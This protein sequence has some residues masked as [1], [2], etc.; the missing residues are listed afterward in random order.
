[1]DSLRSAKST[2]SPASANGVSLLDILTE[3][4]ERGFSRAVEILS[5]HKM[6]SAAQFAKLIGVSREAVRAMRQLHEVLVVKGAKR[7]LHFPKR[8]VTPN[9]GLLA[10]LSPLFDL[11]SGFRNLPFRL[12]P[13]TPDNGGQV[14]PKRVLR[15][16]SNHL[17]GNQPSDWIQHHPE[18]DRDTAL[19]ASQRGKV[20][21]STRGDDGCRQQIERIKCCSVETV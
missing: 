18:L 8:Q 3:L 17:F 14:G 1:V 16:D 12:R 9:G 15:I 13:A 11:L 20:G 6:L 2:G 5:G 7:R 10:E 19:S 4:Q 21:K